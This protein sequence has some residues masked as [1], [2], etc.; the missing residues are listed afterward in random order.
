VRDNRV[1][2]FEDKRYAY[3]GHGRLIEKKTA[4]HA[5]Q[6]FH[7]DDEHRLIEVVTTRHVNDEKRRSTQSTRFDYDALGR[8]VAK[9][10]SFGTT[11]F[12]WEGMRL[13]EERRASQVVSY[14]YEPN[15]YVPLARIDASGENTSDGGIATEGEHALETNDERTAPSLN[16]LLKWRKTTNPCVVVKPNNLILSTV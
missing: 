15:S 11:R 13:I 8:R 6:R 9:H 12:I 10:D 14:V 5:V 4:K 3:D 16:D 2:V 7:W 1:R